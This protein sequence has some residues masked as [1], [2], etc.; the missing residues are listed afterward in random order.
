MTTSRP[1]IGGI[2]RHYKGK[3]YLMHGIARHSETLEEV[4][5]YECLYENDLG[6]MWVRPLEMFMG[7]IE[8]D[9]QS[10]P[11]FRLID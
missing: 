7:C 2:Y 11:R 10:T 4:V 6:K 3:R 1:K 5:Y 8:I 9:G